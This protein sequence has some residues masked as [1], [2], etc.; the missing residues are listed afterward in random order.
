VL[1]KTPLIGT[2]Y[3]S[4]HPALKR[5]LTELDSVVT[6]WGLPQITLTEA[7]RTRAENTGIYTAQYLAQ[8]HLCMTAADYR[9]S[10]LPY[11]ATDWDRVQKWLKSKYQKPMWEV[12]VHDIGIG[13]HGHLAICDFNWRRKFEQQEA[14]A[15][16]L[17]GQA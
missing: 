9:S 4:L 16:R 3:A 2:Q 5:A 1:F 13:L 15:K 12:L 6:G 7:L 17:G 11:S 14:T 10:G 8:D